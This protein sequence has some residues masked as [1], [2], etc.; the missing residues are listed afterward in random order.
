MP[1]VKPIRAITYCPPDNGDVSTRI[2]PPYDILDE[3]AKSHLLGADPHN[4]VAIDLPHLPPK[5]VG[6]DATYEQAGRTYRQWLEEGVL[7]RRHRPA[8]FVYRQSFELPDDHGRTWQ[9]LGLIAAVAVRPFGPSRDGLGGI[10][11]H[12][13]TFDA[14]KEDRLKLMRATRAQLSP[15][16]GLYSDPA[17]EIRELIGAFTAGDPDFFGTT[18]ADGVLHEVRAMVDEA[19]IDRLSNILSAKD[20]FIADGHHRYTTALNY[21]A[22]GAGPKDD[23]DHPAGFCMFVLIAM[24]DPAMRVL[25]THRVL[26][27]M[28]AFNFEQFAAGAKGLLKIEPFAPDPGAGAGQLAD[29]TALERDLPGRGPH[30]IGLYNPKGRGA[31]LSIA[32]PCSPD[33]LAGYFPHQTPAWRQLDVAIV[34]HL[35]VEKICQP[36]FFTSGPTPGQVKWHFPH[37]LRE[38][39]DLALTSDNQLGLI[40]QPPSLESIR[41]ISEAGELMPQKSTFFYPKLATGLVIH[42]LRM[43]S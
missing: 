18:A 41:Q 38:L 23:P 5:T 7:E 16:F 32:T 1:A 3:T 20:I 40:L 8:L 43:E 14:P 27:G 31:P 29:L 22:E 35:I 25:P 21:K 2:A 15:I 30:A 37:S 34:R 33:P 42:P 28:S 17:G 13:Q 36:R 12:E 9:R 24:Q 39:L 26:G 6:P 4:I 19:Q 10:Y 11:P